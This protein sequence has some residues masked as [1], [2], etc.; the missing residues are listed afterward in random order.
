MEKYLFVPKFSLEPERICFYNQVINLEKERNDQILREN[1]YFR[2]VHDFVN[3]YSNPIVK[4][5]SHNFKLSANATRT[6]KRKINWLYYLAR[7]KSVTT[8]TGKKIY[9]FKISFITLTLPS[10]QR[11]PTHEVTSDLF[12]QFMTEIRQRTKIEN[13]VWRLEFQKNGNVHYHI[14]SDMYLDYFLI[15]RIWNRILKKANYIKSYTRKHENLSLHQYNDLYN[16]NRKIPFAK[17]AERYAKGKAE[18]WNQPNTV[19]VKNVTK[20]RAV[21]S[22]I[23]KYFTKSEKTGIKCNPLDTPENS[24]SIRLW[25]CSRSL[26]KLETITD[27]CESFEYDIRGIVETCKNVKT[28]TMD[29][30]Y[31]LFF[32]MQNLERDAYQIVNSI[33][34][35][36]AKSQEYS[37][38]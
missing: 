26:S 25:F 14:V 32:R 1:D 7:S 28:W 16:Q 23:A 35:N 30:A 37:P 10:P 33:L 15:L 4:K 20:G 5:D 13:Y 2:P 12:N 6:L 34:R 29:Y 17:M 3:T 21:Q 27:F 24:K 11:T 38:G 18:K 22:Y 19:D 36:Y 9:N 8:Y 31:L